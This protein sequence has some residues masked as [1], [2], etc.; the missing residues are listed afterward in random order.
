[1]DT[2]VSKISLLHSRTAEGQNS[3]PR[4][5]SVPG[6]CCSN[7][8]TQGRAEQHGFPTPGMRQGERPS[9]VSGDALLSDHLKAQPGH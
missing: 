7:Q 5:W 4:A 8:L 1:M 2:G 3:G 9:E 6:P